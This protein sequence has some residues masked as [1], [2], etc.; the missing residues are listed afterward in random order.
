MY[1]CI[2]KGAINRP[3]VKYNAMCQ[4][5]MLQPRSGPRAPRET[6]S[7]S[8]HIEVAGWLYVVISTSLSVYS[9][10]IFAPYTEKNGLFWPSFAAQNT[11]AL[12]GAILN[13]HLSTIHASNVTS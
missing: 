4:A 10:G 12:R 11:L 2:K 1:Q 5:V 13:R 9:L 3:R 6:W 8:R 7:T